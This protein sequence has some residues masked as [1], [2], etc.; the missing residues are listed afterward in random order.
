MSQ[1]ATSAQLLSS[2]ESLRGALQRTR[3]L[4]DLPG[5]DAVRHERRVALDQLDD[6]VL[7]RLANL[8]APA[9]IVVGGSTGAGKS[10][11]VNSLVGE[12]V[13]VPG[14]LRPTTRAP[15]LACNPK[16]KP[17]FEDSRILPGLARVSRH[18]D[19]SGE[20][21]APEPSASH[22]VVELVTTD[23]LPENIAILDAPDVD[24]VVSEN[25]DLATQLLAAADLWVFVTTAARYA[26]A[27]PWDHLRT[28][29]ARGVSLVLVLNR[30]PE[31]ALTPIGEHLR[32]MLDDQ[33][34]GGVHVYGIEEQ[35][36]V[37]GRIETETVTELST[38]LTRLA[39]D[40]E[41]RDR[42]V[43]NTLRGVIDDLARRCEV[44]A[45]SMD[46]QKGT[47][48]F[49]RGEVAGSFDSARE[50]LR[51]D[52]RDGA[53][54]RGEVLDR[55]QEVVGTG[56]LIRQ[57]ESRLGRLRDK[58][59]SAVTGRAPAAEKFTGALESGVAVLVRR[60]ATEAGRQA[61][62]DWTQHPAGKQLISSSEDDLSQP[63]ADLDDRTA[64]SIREWQGGLVD[65]LRTEG[66]NKRSTARFLSYGVNGAAL[67]LMVAVF[68]Q[69][70]GLTGAEVAIAGGTSAVGTKLL[71][72]L[73]GD[74]AVRRLAEQAR[75]DLD[76][77]VG[78]V[79]DREAQRFYRQLDS[80][81]LDIDAANELRAAG[82]ELANEIRSGA[83]DHAGKHRSP[84]DGT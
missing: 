57:L 33:G 34:L 24:S 83:L 73:L 1:P 25:R 66:A 65:M 28:A 18:V 11:L 43:R 62:Q 51:E 12:S 44:I 3:L 41:A 45:G 84:N 52:V 81:S 7:P 77:R 67:V 15:V 6:H 31:G 37:E 56:E 38:W 53:V 27:V 68:A 71:E 16:S 58:V 20:A 75:T 17:W 19:A 74:Q 9:L 29:A 40:T 8:D 70:G 4:F 72:A 5:I 63:S 60:R 39:T 76:R 23:R 64:N 46:E 35:P 50:L 47:V 82:R 36:L 48:E 78:V 42:I 55:W 80:I 54:L 2:A 59:T 69:T 13:T 32:T 10:T 49:L 14:V 79:L 30:V 61:Y 21:P 22:S 26:D